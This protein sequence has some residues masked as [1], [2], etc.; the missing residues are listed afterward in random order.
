MP[1]GPGNWKI[2]KGSIIG[3]EERLHQNVYNLYPI[4]SSDADVGVIGNDLMYGD[5][6][7]YPMQQNI[8]NQ[9]TSMKIMRGR[10]FAA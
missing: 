8:L 4:L 6:T 5:S 10:G 3:A 1:L 9:A 7:W 2:R